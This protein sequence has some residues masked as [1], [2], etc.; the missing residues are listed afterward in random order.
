MTRPRALVVEDDASIA[1]SIGDVLFSLGHELEH[2]TNQSDA[3]S[4]IEAGAYDYILL[5]LTI[6]ARPHRGGASHECGANLLRMIRERFGPAQLP[7]I[8]MTAHHDKGLNQAGELSRLGVTAFIAK[9]FPES[10]RTLAAVVR[11]ALK[12]RGNELPAARVGGVAQRAF[13]GGL[14]VFGLDRIEL[15]GETIAEKGE[16]ANYWSVLHALKAKRPD[17]RFIPKRGGE[18]AKQF[19]S[20]KA[21][22]NTVSSCINDLRERIAKAMHTRGL[23]C[24]KN[25]VIESGGPGY[26]FNQWIRIEE[27]DGD[28]AGT[29]GDRDRSDVPAPP[30]NVPATPANVPLN[31]R[32]HWVLE[33]LRSR[34]KFQRRDLEQHF[35][36]GEKTAKRDL[37]DLGERGLIAFQRTPRP[38]HYTLAKK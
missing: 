35:K 12:S 3:Q 28:I 14:M 11:D 38:G 4:R 19:K 22:E 18:L 1:E 24:K 6:P 29:C 36:V 10:G 2:V 20:D 25:D 31:D 5:D 30:V 33:Q 7:V 34:E 9:P 21:N 17:G 27:R 23:R 37:N 15:L 8:I 26:R 13:D 16:R 32:Q